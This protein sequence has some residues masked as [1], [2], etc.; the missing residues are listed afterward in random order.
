MYKKWMDNLIAVSKGKKPG[1][2]PFCGSENTGYKEVVLNQKTHIGY[3][4]IWCSDCKKAFHVSR[5]HFE[6]P[7]EIGTVMPKA[8]DY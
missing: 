1:K 3:A 5:G 7:K 2:C 6:K 8:L 4:D